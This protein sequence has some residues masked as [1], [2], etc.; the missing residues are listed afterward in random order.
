MLLAKSVRKFRLHTTLV[1]PFVLQTVATVGLVGYLSFRNGQQTINDLANQLNEEI[2]AR[3][4][5]HVVSYLRKSQDT[6]WLTHAN[7]VSGNL[8]LKDF[9]GLQRYFWQVVHRGDFESY[10][11]YGNA[12]GEFIGVEYQEDRTVQLKIRTLAIAPQRETYELDDQGKRKTLLK[13]A[14]YDPRTRPWYRSALTSRNPTWSEIYPFFSSKN[15]VLGIS[16]VYPVFD[17]KG[18][19]MGVLC[20]NVRLTQITDFINDLDIS[21]HG[22][23]FI[24]ERTGDLVASSTLTQ[25]FRVIDKA[26]EQEIERIL[27]QESDNPVIQATAQ[28]LLQQF[29]NFH[30]IYNSQSLRFKAGDG[31]WYYAQVLPI[32]DGYGIDWLAVVVVPEND[33]MAQINQNTRHTLF[34]CVGALALSIAIGMFT[35]HRITRPILRVSQASDK[36]AQGGNLD[37]HIAPSVI[38]EI[39]TLANSFN[40]MA[41]QLKASFDALRHSEA[42]NRA[43]VNTIPDLM[44]RARGDGTYLDIIGSDRLRTVA[45]EPQFVVGHTVEE[46]LPTDL[47]AQRLH[48]INQALATGELQVYEHRLM[49]DGQPQDEEVRILVLGEDEVLIMVRDITARKQ[50]EEALRLANEE[51]E[52]RVEQRT[53]ELFQEKERAERLL[54]NVLPGEIAERLKS[55]N[56]SPADHFEE[57]TILF[58]DIVGFTTLAAKL[59]PMQLVSSLNQIFSAFDHLT[60]TYGLEKIKT[61]GDAYMVVGGLPTAR[62]DHASAIAEM[63]L[64]MQAHMQTLD[65]L[66]GE[67]LQLRI[68]INTGPVIA[69]VIGIK[70]FIYDLWGDAVNLASRMESQ[71][72]P[73]AIQVTEATYV[74]LKDQYVFE[75]RGTIAVKG[76][77]DMLTYW[78][79]RR[80]G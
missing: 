29:G 37:E 56:E 40:R 16:P 33:F 59:D 15:T 26:G 62:P 46:S 21:S 10:L 12:K 65:S 22:Q 60:E 79:V 78:L 38:T 57:V 73:G 71:G 25:P 41:E 45:G 6:L 5:Q 8:D 77:G 42:T 64:D 30:A 61:I 3:I 75:S 66:L 49:L 50:A 7:V 35:A 2:S 47:A 52:Q 70:K 72:R 17:A 53:A 34:L 4:E 28:Q 24:M 69:G 39:N 54:L 23:S 11:S 32:Q 80:R 68:G 43:I 18:E 51:L 58:A 63:A 20:I 48:Y 36:L 44:I 27:A 14:E 55:S 67:S 76:R 1:V 74:R 13:T 19:L 31:A 9:E